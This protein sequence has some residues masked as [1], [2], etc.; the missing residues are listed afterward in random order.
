MS[1]FPKLSHFHAKKEPNLAES[2]DFQNKMATIALISSC[3]SSALKT[4]KKETNFDFSMDHPFHSSRK[5]CGAKLSSPALHQLLIFN[6]GKNTLC[7]KSNSKKSQKAQLCFNRMN[8]GRQSENHLLKPHFTTFLS[9]R[10]KFIF[11]P[12]PNL[13][14]T[15]LNLCKTFQL[16]FFTKQFIY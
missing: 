11:A 3:R 9:K 7:L 6:L 8:F 1:H 13:F 14:C 16:W 2:D 12:L 15:F 10:A 5:A 4:E